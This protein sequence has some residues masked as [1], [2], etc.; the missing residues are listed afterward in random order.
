MQL[1][2]TPAPCVRSRTSHGKARMFAGNCVTRGVAMD[3][4]CYLP[5]RVMTLTAPLISDRYTG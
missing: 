5:L 4:R 1:G 2:S 3:S